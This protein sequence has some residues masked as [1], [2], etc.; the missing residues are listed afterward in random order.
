MTYTNVRDFISGA[1][2]GVVGDYVLYN[3][4]DSFVKATPEWAVYGWG[5]FVAFNGAIVLWLKHA[6][7]E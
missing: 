6:L 4:V 3:V 1:F 5:L 2:A 7:S